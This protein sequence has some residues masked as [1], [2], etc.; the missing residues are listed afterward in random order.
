MIGKAG[1]RV[2]FLIAKTGVR[3]GFLAT[4]YVFR[5]RV[6]SVSGHVIGEQKDI[7]LTLIVA[8]AH[9]LG[10]LP[11]GQFDRKQGSESGFRSG[12]F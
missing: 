11:A 6:I 10:F 8:A 3:V 1:V 2:G 4:R 12:L 5:W 9:V 7:G